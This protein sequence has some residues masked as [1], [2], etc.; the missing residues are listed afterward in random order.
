MIAK[1]DYLHDNTRMYDTNLTVADIRRNIGGIVSPDLLIGYINQATERLVNSGKWV[2]NITSAV[3]LG[4]NGYIVLPR[5]LISVL[6]AV[7]DRCPMP[8]FSQWHQYVETGPGFPHEIKNMRGKLVD[9]GAGFCTQISIESGNPGAIVVYSN[10]PDNGITVRIFGIDA[11]TGR[12]VI[13]A[14]G[15]PGEAVELGSPSVTTL[16]QFSVMTGFSKPITKGRVR[17]AVNGSLGEYQIAEYEP[18]ETNPR[19]RRYQVGETD[20]AIRVLCQRKFV[21]VYNES[22]WV[23]P[24]NFG[25]IKEMIRCIHYEDNTDAENAAISEARAIKFLNDEARAFRG[26]QKMPSPDQILGWM[27]PT[28]SSH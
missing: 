18:S 19:Y 7:F 5:H 14:D 3:F 16:N 28:T 6:G 9:E 20:K 24:G 12:E 8:T 26:G 13:D 2:G 21:P 27:T 22:D 11:A 10:S 17:L 4:A 23:H 15:L 25:A 1:G